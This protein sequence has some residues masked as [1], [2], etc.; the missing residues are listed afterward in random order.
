MTQDLELLNTVRLKAQTW[1]SELFDKETRDSVK[2]MLE[3]DEEALIEAFYKN[4]DFGTGGLRGIMGAGTNRVNKYTIGMATQ[5]LAN[6][7]LTSFMDLDQIKVAIA[8]DS[9]NN[10][11][12][13]AETTAQVFAAN[14]IMV[15][16]FDALRPTPELSFAIRELDCQSGVVITA[17]HNPKEYNGYKVYW[18]DGGQI[19][20][21]HDNAI[22]S[23][24][25]N[26]KSISEVKFEGNSD[27]VHE[28]GSEIDQKYLDQLLSLSL[29][30]D[31]IREQNG[32]KI[33]YT[34]I[35]G[36]G[37]SLVP[38]T[39]KAFGFGE[40]YNVPEQ[41]IT[42]G[43]FPTVFSPNPEEKAALNMAIE[44]ARELD[45]DL[46]MAT[47]PD[48]DRVGIAVKDSDGEFI[49]LNGK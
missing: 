33:V 22:I 46:V 43:D 35:H 34:P 47:D 2:D 17:S 30:P 5:G 1:T 20:S 3:H 49:L 28:I 45:A 29:N 7:L 26:I 16:L 18:D 11:R 31:I 21:P 40:V 8:Y 39:L 27:L 19:I 42:D 10:S 44:R 15:Y 48:A 41:D 13:F 4:L 12:F 9:R 32:L 37:V 24:V 23:E 38:D 14:G 6:Y 25:G 36:S